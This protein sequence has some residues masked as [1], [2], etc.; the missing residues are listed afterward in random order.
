MADVIVIGGGLAG[1]ATAYFLAA[2]GVDTLLL[3][4]G[5]LN[6]QA[7]GCNSG[8]LHVQIPFEPFALE[9]DGWAKNF[10]PVLP[11]L[12]QAVDLWR[13]LPGMLRADLE[14]HTH[15]GVIAASTEHD[16]HLLERKVLLEKSVGIHAYMLTRSELRNLAPYLSERMVGGAFC[17][18]EGK[19][20]PL[21]ATPA[22]ATAAQKL[23][24][25]IHRRTNVVGMARSGSGY[26]VQTSQG[27][28]RA[29]RIV[30]AA[31]A[32]AGRIAA[33]LGV[34]LA[35]EGYPIQVSVT[36]PAQ[37]LIPHLVYYTGEKLTLKQTPL[38]TFLIGGGWPA[39]LDGWGRPAVDPNSLARNMA[40]ALEAVPCLAT[41]NV[42]RSWAAIVN[43]TDDW[44]P[45]LG[46]IPS[47]PGLYMNFFPWLGFTASPIAARITASLIQGLPPPVN[48][49]LSPF[50]PN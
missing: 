36:E 42:V 6:S 46:E 8:S 33:M 34:K 41:I 23:G 30:N 10:A 19:A 11:L 2:D 29:S 37:P 24:A 14:V 28:Y 1:A 39:R 47:A 17:P 16:L 9:G 27:E 48:C 21:L 45:L 49:D 15:G 40:V 25:R 38:G 13:S 7:S 43:G 44:K 50:R 26:I 20:N 35:V 12:A 32:E 22:F 31:G 4:R 3:E 5:E 18:T